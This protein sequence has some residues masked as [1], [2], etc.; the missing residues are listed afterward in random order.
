MGGG[1]EPQAVAVRDA[2]AWGAHQ[3]QPSP[4]QGSLH[5]FHALA[6]GTM[7]KENKS[8]ASSVHQGPTHPSPQAPIRA[9]LAPLLIIG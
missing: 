4:L 8:S 6:A 3:V 5:V 1:V 9:I 7:I 2:H